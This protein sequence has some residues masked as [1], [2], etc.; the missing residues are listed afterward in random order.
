MPQRRTAIKDVRKN[1]RNKMRNMDI[2]TDLKKME[3]TFLKSIADKNK[4][5]AQQNLKLLYKKIDKATKRNIFH[6]NTAAR[7]KSRFIKLVNNLA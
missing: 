2:K 1:Y 4:T 5:E 3:K 6:K 7:Q